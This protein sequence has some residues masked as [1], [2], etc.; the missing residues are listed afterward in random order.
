MKLSSWVLLPVLLCLAACGSPSPAPPRA[1]PTVESVDPGP[2]I[3]FLASSGVV[4]T[5]RVVPIRES[6]LSFPIAAS[7]AEVL[8]REGDAVQAGQVLAALH[9]PDLQLSVTSAELALKAAELNQV[10][11]APRLDRPP[12]RRRQAEAETELAREKLYVAQAE[13]AQTRL[14]APFDATLVD[15]RIQPGE[16]AQRGGVVMVLGDLSTMQVETTDLSERDVDLVR[17]GQAA[18]VYIEALDL[19][20]PGR[21]VRISPVADTVGG[22]VV[23]PVTIEFAEQPAGLMWGMTA[24]VEIRME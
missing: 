8:V 1:D 10:Y 3:E 9:S 2:R 6:R 5:A 4:A 23:F 16:F 21:V 24:E 7:V 13:Y 20:V 12:E 18:N 11:W 15:L 17:V 14:L 22:D 19:L